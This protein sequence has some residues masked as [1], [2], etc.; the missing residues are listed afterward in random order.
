[1]IYSPTHG[2]ALYRLSPTELNNDYRKCTD[3]TRVKTSW[4]HFYITTHFHYTNIL[5]GSILTV[6]LR[7]K[8][9]F[10]GVNNKFQ[11]VRVNTGNNKRIIGILVPT[12]FI[13]KLKAQISNLL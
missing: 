3:M 6:F 8:E 9:L 10:D 2:K 4:D 1:M 5:S 11:M 12:H 7:A 13:S